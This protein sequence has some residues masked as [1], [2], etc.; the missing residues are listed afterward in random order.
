MKLSIFLTIFILGVICFEV[1]HRLLM[2]YEE[3]G[4][5][6]TIQHKAS[7]IL[8]FSGLVMGIIGLLEIITRIENQDVKPPLNTCDICHTSSIEIE[9]EE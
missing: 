6:E 2:K 7:W 9:K 5:K 3:N 4:M 8:A 1:G